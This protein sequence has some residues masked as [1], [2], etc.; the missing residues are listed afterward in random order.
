MPKTMIQTNSIIEKLKKRVENE[1]KIRD[2]LGHIFDFKSVIPKGTINK[3]SLKNKIIIIDFI[4]TD[5][6][7]IRNYLESKYGVIRDINKNN[8]TRI[9]IKL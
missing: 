9:E 7:Q 1:V 8:L 6:S 2:A 4:N 5:S 3:I